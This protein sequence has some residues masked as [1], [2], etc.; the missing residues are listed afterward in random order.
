MGGSSG[1]EEI[2]LLAIG[3]VATVQGRPKAL[4]SVCGSN[5]SRRPFEADLGLHSDPAIHRDAR[6]S[7][8][9]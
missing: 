9:L 4:S 7:F 8:S 3:P 6:E 2:A 1:N 5:V